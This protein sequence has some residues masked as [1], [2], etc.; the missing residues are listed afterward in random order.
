[1][2]TIQIHTDRALRP[3]KPMHGVGGGPLT[4]NFSYNAIPQF[5]EAGI[6]FSRTHDIEYPY[7]AGEFVD[8]HCIFKDFDKDVNDPASY[9]FIFTDEYFKA[10]L[11]SGAKPFYRLGST[12]EHQPIKR[13]IHPPKDFAKWGE[14][15]SHIIAHYNEGWADGFHMGIEYWEIWNE[16]DIGQCWTGTEE[17]IMALYDAAATIIKRDHPDVKIGGLAFTSSYAALAEK[18][19]AHVKEAGTPLDFFS[20]HGYCHKPEE[21]RANSEHADML[22][23]K[24]GFADTVE[25]IFDEW[26]YVV[27]W[28]DLQKS[29]DLHRTGFCASFVSAVMSEVQKTRTDKLMYY[30]VQMLMGGNWNGVFHALPQKQHAAQAPVACD[31]PYYCFKAWNELYKAGTE[32]MCEAP[33][34]CYVTA[35]YSAESGKTVLLLSYYNDDAFYGDSAPA[36]DDFVFVLDGVSAKDAK[37]YI[38]DNDRTYEEVPFADGKL[39]LHGNSF[40]L[41]AF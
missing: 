41:I 8:I 1:M 4:S 39:S 19:L 30:D 10:V 22:L 5:R 11:E 6:P 17:E 38:V 29:V 35:A 23:K 28:D 33:E 13:Y 20:W 15:C 36:D 24:Y 14:I 3:I 21:A 18:W 40:A 7:G 32:V 26:N 31:K 16:P 34:N 27:R 9:N 37:A 25:S 12:I 2:K